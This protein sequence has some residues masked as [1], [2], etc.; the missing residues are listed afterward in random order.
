MKI[1]LIT[2]VSR[3]AGSGARGAFEEIVGFQNR[4]VAGSTEIRH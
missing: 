2:V 3:E 4:L 1:K